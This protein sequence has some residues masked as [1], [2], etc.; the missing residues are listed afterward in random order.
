MEKK[1]EINI[2]WKNKDDNSIMTSDQDANNIESL[3]KD[4][5][6][7]KDI[8]INDN[9]EE[10]SSIELSFN[11]GSMET[12]SKKNFIP[13][14]DLIKNS[15]KNPKTTSANNFKNSPCILINEIE[16]VFKF[17]CFYLIYKLKIPQKIFSYIYLIIICLNL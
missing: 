7:K 9:N 6:V 16:E 14:I 12:I 1:D 3:K 17:Y 10:I 8:V 4:F 11:S 2:F 15:E 13:K 5:I